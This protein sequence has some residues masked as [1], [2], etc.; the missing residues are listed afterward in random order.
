MGQRG[1]YGFCVGREE[2]LCWVVVMLCCYCWS[3]GFLR[4]C[5]RTHNGRPLYTYILKWNESHTHLVRN[6]YRV[7]TKIIWYHGSAG[8]FLENARPVQ[9]QAAAAA[10][11]QRQRDQIS[12]KSNNF[13]QQI[14]ILICNLFKNDVQFFAECIGIIALVSLVV[15]KW[16][17]FPYVDIIKII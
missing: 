5:V 9:D 12:L 17:N 7:V 2:L 8:L 4:S 11:R 3:N 14:R 15:T 6:L 13:L 1:K 10:I 16:S